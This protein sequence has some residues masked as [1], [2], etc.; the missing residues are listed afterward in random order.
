MARNVIDR[1]D[2]LYDK[3]QYRRM[4]MGYI[5]LQVSYEHA[6]HSPHAVRFHLVTVI[7]ADMSAIITS[8]SVRGAVAIGG[9]I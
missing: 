6:L 4:S 8:G 2:N 1:S 9:E 3:D 5:V 7:R